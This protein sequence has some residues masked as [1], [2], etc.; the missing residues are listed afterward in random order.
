MNETLYF[1]KYN[2]NWAD[3]MDI[4]G[5]LIFT[6]KE[7]DDYFS[8]FEKYFGTNLVYTFYVG[9]NEEITHDSFFDFKSCFTITEITDKEREVLE[10]LN[11]NGYG[12]YP[13]VD[14]WDGEDDE[15]AE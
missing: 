1:L 14:V 11:L 7:M 8:E 4:E 10:K 3:E 5:G 13:C 2:N 12:H 6:K 9:T 15:E